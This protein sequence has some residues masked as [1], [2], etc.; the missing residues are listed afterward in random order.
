MGHHISARKIS[1]V[2]LCQNGKILQVA[3]ESQVQSGG[4]T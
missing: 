3:Q 4:Q 2:K 1:R